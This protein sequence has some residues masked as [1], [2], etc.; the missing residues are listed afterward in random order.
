MNLHCINEKHVVAE[1]NM[2]KIK[3]LHVNANETILTV[4]YDLNPAQLQFS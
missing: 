4:F 1:T 2:R 3:V